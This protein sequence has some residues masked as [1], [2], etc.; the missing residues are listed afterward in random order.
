V[1]LIAEL[2]RRNV[3]RMAGL[4]LVGAWLATQLHVLAEMGP[5][6]LRLSHSAR[7][8]QSGTGFCDCASRKA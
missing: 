3:I 8:F 2:K 7:V 4:Y 5:P 6:R 1:N